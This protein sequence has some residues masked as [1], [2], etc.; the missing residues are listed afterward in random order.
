MMNQTV[1]VLQL[2]NTA[3]Y[4]PVFPR[5]YSPV[6]PLPLLLLTILLKGK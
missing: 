1:P 4:I 3:E 6:S 5:Q 2:D